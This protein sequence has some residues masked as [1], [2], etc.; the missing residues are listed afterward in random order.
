M[1]R[2]IAGFV[3]VLGTGVLLFAGP[4]QADA[5]RAYGWWYAANLGLPVA[6]PPPS[7]PGDGLYIEN[8][9]TGPTAFSALSFTVPSGAAIGRLSLHVAGSAMLSQAPIACPLQSA[10]FKPAQGGAWSER[11]AYDCQKAQKTATMDASKSTL[12]FDVSPFL[13]D[14]T[15]AFAI[16]AS[17]PLDHAGFDKPGPDTLTVTNAGAPPSAAPAIGFATTPNGSS[18]NVVPS[19]GF[20]A[21]GGLSATTTAGAPT[22]GAPTAPAA[23]P[24]TGTAASSPFATIA[25]PTPPWRTNVARVAGIAALLLVLIAWSEG[26][27]ILGGRIQPLSSPLRTTSRVPMANG[28]TD[29]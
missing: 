5:P 23:T 9:V 2:L 22:T 8:G 6:A 26:Y 7:A 16:L 12:T 15:V 19:A 20:T 29:S 18:G 28:G 17:G 14:G 21:P 11:P 1:R 13:R 4:S 27:G 3:A 24:P 10:S 25:T